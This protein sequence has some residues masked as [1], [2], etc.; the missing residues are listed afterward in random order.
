MYDRYQT[1]NQIMLSYNRD[2]GA[3]KINALAGWE[4]QHKEA[5]NFYAQRDLA[6]AMKYLFAGIDENQKAVTDPGGVWEDAN[7]ALIGRLNYAYADRYIAEAQF[8]YDGSSK[9]MKGHQW[10][11]FPSGSLG[12]RISEEPLFK[13]ISALDFVNQLKVRASYGVLGDDGAS[14]YQWANG[15]TYPAGGE[16]DQNKGWYNGYVPGWVFDGEFVYGAAAMSI[17]NENITWFTSHTFDLG[18]DFEA[19]KGLFGFAFDWFSRRREGRLVIPSSEI[20]TVLG[21]GVSEQN[22][23]SDRH[24]GID[25]E[26]S[27]KNTIAGFT[28]KVK[29]IGTITRNMYLTA[30]QNGPYA[31]SYDKWRHDNLN[32]RYQGVQFGYEGAG[33][34]T[35]WDDIRSYSVYHDNGTLPGDYK[36]LDWNG[37]GEINGLDEHPY[38]YDQTPWMNYSLN[39]E[40]A[41]KGFDLNILFQ[42]SA[43]GSM[44]YKEPLY[45]IW[46]SY[47]GGALEQYLDRWHPVTQNAWDYFDPYDPSLQWESGY[48]GLTGHNP[49]SNS[50]F[51]RVST[52]YLR[53]KSVELGYTLPKFGAAQNVNV[54]FFANAY[55]LFTITGVKFVDPEHPEDALGRLYPLN[56]TYTLGL[57][58]SF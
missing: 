49:V 58:L 11:F 2:F 1:L 19:W 8:R 26:L 23:N 47:G 40:A 55:N 9:F 30:V 22:L 46:G 12:W 39:F 3:H 51:N 50:D 10:G 6:F 57:T 35:G 25:L 27:H 33:R 48:Y 56:K 43:L 15:Y 20:P 53:L 24:F 14:A 38:A 32:N 34:Y 28:Y 42:G 21:S 31:N 17:P 16:G 36:Y 52:S 41:Y 37:D 18:V 7:A 13:S 29:A 44:E 54:R 45:S 4:T 5:D